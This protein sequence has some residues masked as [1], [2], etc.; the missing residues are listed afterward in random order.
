[1][2]IK[3]ASSSDAESLRDHAIAG[4]SIQYLDGLWTATATIAPPREADCDFEENTDYNHGVM[5]PK[6]ATATRAEC[7]AACARE[8]TCAA[9]V[10]AGVSGCWLKR[11]SD[12]SK[13]SSVDGV[14]ACVV[15]PSQHKG[16]QVSVPGRVPGDLITDLH[17]AGLVGDPLYELN[18]LNASIWDQNTWTY[19]TYFDDIK[20]NDASNGSSGSVV[21]RHLVFDGIKM[22]SR[23]YLDGELLGNTTDQFLR[24]SFEMPSSGIKRNKENGKHKLEVIFDPAI[25]CGGRWMACTGG[26]DWAPYT[27]TAQ[28]KIPTFTKGIWKSVYVVDVGA[29]AI[30]DMVPQ[31]SYAGKDYPTEP[32]KDNTV[33]PL[34][35]SQH[36][37]FNVLVK[38]F[39]GLSER[40]SVL[41]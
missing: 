11:T 2:A 31:I 30:T 24:Y 18:F 16:R 27:N 17:N 15:K 25:D 19:T 23:I 12:L 32:M 37:G 22:G 8:S 13:K 40:C 36:G 3:T 1:M 9:A 21:S 4:S 7:C 5:G 28:D 39:I 14:T 26:W 34:D 6:I 10:F 20:D 38:A 41:I 33:E 29:V 35:T